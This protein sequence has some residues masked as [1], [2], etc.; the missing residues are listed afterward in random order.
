[1]DSQVAAWIAGIGAILFATAGVALAIREVRRKERRDALAIISNMEHVILD[2]Q[3]EAIAWRS[4]VFSLRRILADHG[5]PSPDPP[6]LAEYTDVESG[7][8]LRDSNAPGRGVRGLRRRR[9]RGGDAADN[10]DSPDPG[11]AG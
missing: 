4:Y 11:T 1:V 10:G 8:L 2:Q 5:I 9:R 6:L 3:N 7:T